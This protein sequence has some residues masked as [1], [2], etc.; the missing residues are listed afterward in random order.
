VP[1]VQPIIKYVDKP[2]IRTIENVIEIPKFEYVDKIIERPMK[3]KVQKFVEVPQIKYL[4]KIV[5]I[6][7]ITTREIIIEVPKE[8][9]VDVE[10]EAIEVNVD[11]GIEQQEAETERETIMIEGEELPAIVSGTTHHWE[12]HMQLGV[13]DL[14]NTMQLQDLAQVN[15]A[16]FP[17]AQDLL[18]SRRELAD[19]AQQGPDYN[20]GELQAHVFQLAEDAARVAQGARV[21]PE[22]R[23]CRRAVCARRATVAAMPQDC[24]HVL[25]MAQPQGLRRADRPQGCGVLGQTKRVEPHPGHDPRAV[26]L[27][28]HSADDQRHPRHLAS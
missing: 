7:K 17:G 5:D 3:K 10:E 22:A 27:T 26:R 13:P 20:P 11:L 12:S 6:P 15:K 25:W 24:G 16:N 9:H 14:L 2:V 23:E 4:D 1:K 19:S 21:I 8:T 18:A 28:E